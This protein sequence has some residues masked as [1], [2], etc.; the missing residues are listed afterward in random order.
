MSEFILIEVQ[1]SRYSSSAI[2]GEEKKYLI[3]LHNIYLLLVTG[4]T[5]R[6]DSPVIKLP[7]KGFM[8]PVF[9][10]DRQLD[11]ERKTFTVSLK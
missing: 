11:R 10:I 3:V 2:F 8:L 6:G 7:H 5:G 1:V 4:C 9:K